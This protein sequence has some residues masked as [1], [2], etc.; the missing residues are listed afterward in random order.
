MSAGERS[1]IDVVRHDPTNTCLGSCFWL[2]CPDRKTD[3]LV[4][5]LISS[6]QLADPIIPDTDLDIN[7]GSRVRLN[8]H[9][10]APRYPKSLHQIP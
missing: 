4:F 5:P 6:G 9:L 8:H 10:I 3:N 7:R 1:G 2:R